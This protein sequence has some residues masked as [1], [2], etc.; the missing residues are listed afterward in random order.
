MHLSNKLVEEDFYIIETKSNEI[1][2][3]VLL[4]VVGVLLILVSFLMLINV[5]VNRKNRN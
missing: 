1:T 4:L 2:L 3:R 5:Y